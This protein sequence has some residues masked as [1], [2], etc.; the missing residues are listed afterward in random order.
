MKRGLNEEQH[1]GTVRTEEPIGI[2]EVLKEGR[3]IKLEDGSEWHVYYMDSI[4]STHW[5]AESTRVFVREGI[6]YPFPYKTAL[7]RADSGQRVSAKKIEQLAESHA[8]AKYNRQN[9]QSMKEG[10]TERQHVGTVQTEESIGITEVLKDGRIIKLEDGS[11]WHVYFRDS[12]RSI[13]WQP[14]LTRVIVREGIGY[15]FPYI[16]MLERADSGQMVNAKRSG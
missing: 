16:E 11:E 8:D 12:I 5:C 7:E 10:Q 6:G 9:S 14:R 13:H 15:P 4:R 2:T 1:V 3:I